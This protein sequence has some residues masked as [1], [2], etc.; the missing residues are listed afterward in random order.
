MNGNNDNNN[1]RSLQKKN[2]NIIKTWCYRSLLHILPHYK[3]LSLFSHVTSSI[4]YS[5]RVCFFYILSF[6]SSQSVFPRCS[7]THFLSLSFSSSLYLLSLCSSLRYNSF[8]SLYF[9]RLIPIYFISL[10]QHFLFFNICLFHP[11]LSTFYYSLVI[12]LSSFHYFL[13]F[14]YLFL[15]PYPF[16]LQFFFN[17][18]FYSFSLFLPRYLKKK[19]FIFSSLNFQSLILN[20]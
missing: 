13:S 3:T 10:F 14:F 7:L 15:L 12:R 6:P 11:L 17:S 9:L 5:C 19:D 8:L 18:S 2:D 16:Y 4:L 1:K 20:F